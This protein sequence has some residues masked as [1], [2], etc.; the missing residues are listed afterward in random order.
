MKPI[1]RDGAQAART[2]AM[3]MR[4]VPPEGP[5]SEAHPSS[6]CVSSLA[7]FQDRLLND[8]SIEI[9]AKDAEQLDEAATFLPA[10]TMVSI[11]FL[12]GESFASRVDAAVRVAALG[13]KPVPHVSARRLTSE[14]EL[15]G[16]L[17][18]LAGRIALERVFVVAG[19]LP[20]FPIHQPGRL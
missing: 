5:P 7:M 20:P 15:E 2:K 4:T 1:I 18:A 11:T 6:G 14:G 9:T 16:F 10:N 12:P 19:D 3:L 8:F 13:F 17:D